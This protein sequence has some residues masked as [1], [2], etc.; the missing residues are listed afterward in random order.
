MS[1]PDIRTAV[2]LFFIANDGFSIIENL[3]IMGVKMPPIVKNS[4]AVLGKQ[5]GADED[6]P[7][8]AE[9]QANDAAAEISEEE[10]ENKA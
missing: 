4:F 2:I 7:Q 3:G 1:R 5:S 8:Q 10:P 9:G 6:P